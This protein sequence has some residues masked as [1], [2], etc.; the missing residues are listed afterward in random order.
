MPP[1][2]TLAL[3]LAS[4]DE[5]LTGRRSTT[6]SLVNYAS[7]ELETLRMQNKVYQCSSN[8]RS[9]TV[10]TRT[11]GTT[12]EK[13]ESSECLNNPTNCVES[14]SCF[15]SFPPY[16][17]KL[18]KQIKGNDICVD[19]GAQ[20]PEWASLTYGVLLCLSCSGRHR[21]YGVQVSFVRSLHLDSW[22][23]SQTLAM[24]EGGN[25]QLSQFFDRHLLSPISF[26]NS[27]KPCLHSSENPIIE[28]R[29]KTK[30]ASF[31]RQ[32]L[33]LHVEQVIAN[34]LW[35]GRDASRS[36]SCKK[37]KIRSRTRSRANKNLSGGIVSVKAS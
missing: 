33:S 1:L 24:L 32:N 15:P 31:Y 37:N 30:A 27:N 18:L 25:D 36:L 34:G 35:L 11:T 3:A 9:T 5:E 13:N 22:S 21:G 4:I 20:D 14:C 29:Y 2:G 16:C 6:K 12:F 26:S 23:H 10:T 8:D 7:S 19:C 28:R 17:L